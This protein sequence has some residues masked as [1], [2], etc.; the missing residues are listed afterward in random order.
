MWRSGVALTPP[1]SPPPCCFLCGASEDAFALT[2]AVESFGNAML[3]SS[4]RTVRLVPSQ[5]PA[6]LLP[7]S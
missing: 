3:T 4:P 1:R 7:G 6:S 2:L 5:E